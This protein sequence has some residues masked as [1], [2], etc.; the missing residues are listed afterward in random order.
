MAAILTVCTGNICRSP[1]SELVLA[2]RLADLGVHVASAGTRGLAAAPMTAESQSIAAAL[3][4]AP[5]AAAAHRSRLLTEQHV[6]GASFVLAMA[7]EHRQ[8][9]AELS[10][11]HVRTTFTVREFARLAADVTDDDVRR[12][13]DAAGEDPD[14]RLDAAIG[15]IA[16]RRG[17]VLP[18]AGPADDDVIDPY[19]RSWETYKTSTYQLVPALEAVERVVRTALS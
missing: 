2:S 1:L 17:L 12:S 8:S 6:T 11:V 5:E 7:R 18:P 4:V 19:R 3:G 15:L 16:G 13:A 9:V 14:A 10:P